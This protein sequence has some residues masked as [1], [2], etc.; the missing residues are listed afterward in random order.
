MGILKK[1][2]FK[3]NIPLE[4]KDFHDEPISLL[5]TVKETYV[6]VTGSVSPFEREKLFKT[7]S[8]STFKS[9]QSK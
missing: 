4:V 9:I 3:E 1:N 7:G 8:Q 2:R 6:T 5:M